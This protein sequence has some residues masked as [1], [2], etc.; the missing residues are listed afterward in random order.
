MFSAEVV[1]IELPPAMDECDYFP[2][3]WPTKCAT[4]KKKKIIFANLIGKKLY[5]TIV[6]TWTCFYSQDARL[7]GEGCG[8]LLGSEGFPRAKL[9]RQGART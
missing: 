8:V 2:T 5:L 6:L 4:G 3:A 7:G 1:T 9:S